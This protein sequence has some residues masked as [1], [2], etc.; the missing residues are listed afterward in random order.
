MGLTHVS[1]CICTC[2]VVWDT[3]P[4]PEYD[5][6]NNKSSPATTNTTKQETLDT[7][8]TR[9]SDGGGSTLWCRPTTMGLQ[10]LHGQLGRAKAPERARFQGVSVVL[11]RQVRARFILCCTQLLCDRGS[12]VPPAVSIVGS[13]SAAFSQPARKPARTSLP[14]GLFFETA[15][16][17]FILISA[18]P[19]QTR[20]RWY[21][22]GS[23]C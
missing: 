21:L 1:T 23:Y 9:R 11:R 6:N 7:Q 22:G 19:P 17:W 4:C 12:L 16:F 14:V 8:H 10:R 13:K 20:R 15:R 18:L 3:Q 2:G 5:R